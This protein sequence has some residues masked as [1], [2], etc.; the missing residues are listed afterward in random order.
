MLIFLHFPS[1][2][3]FQ[4][5]LMQNSLSRFIRILIFLLIVLNS[6]LLRCLFMLAPRLVMADPA[7]YHMNL[8]HADLSLSLSLPLALFLSPDPG[9]H[10]RNI[11]FSRVFLYLLSLS[12]CLFLYL[13]L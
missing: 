5:F 7:L 13:S 11:Y 3:L 6:L 1:V 4:I 12:L 10:H 8:S 9:L 2:F